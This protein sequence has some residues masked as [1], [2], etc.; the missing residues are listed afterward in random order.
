MPVWVDLGTGSTV[1]DQALGITGMGPVSGSTGT[2]LVLRQAGSLVSQKPARRLGPQ[3]QPG[4]RNS[5]ES[6]AM[7]VSLQHRA[8]GARLGLQ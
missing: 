5:L 1:T 6:W 4:I 7:G 3:G 2:S 8:S